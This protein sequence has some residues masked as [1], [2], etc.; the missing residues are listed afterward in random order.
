M[1]LFADEFASADAWFVLNRLVDLVFI[2]DMV[3]IL[4]TARK[5]GRKMISNHM[6]IACNYLKGWFLFDLA[7]SVPLDV[8]LWLVSG[9]SLSASQGASASRSTK[10]IRVIKIFRIFRILRLLRLKVCETD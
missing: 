7:A 8:I 2:L 9:G 3:V 1:C 4:K 10:L 6:D 5:D